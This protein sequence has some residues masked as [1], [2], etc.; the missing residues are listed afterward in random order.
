MVPVGTTAQRPAATSQG[1]I[2]Y[3]TSLNTLESAN[4]TAWANVGSGSASSTYG[5]NT[6]DTSYFAI[7][8]G[9]TAQRPAN[10][11]LGALRWTSSNTGVEFYVGNN[12]WQMVASTTY[13][14][15]YIIVAGGGGGGGTEQQQGGGGGGAGGV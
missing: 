6:A 4:G 5:A 15:S 3:N 2:R 11:P 8:V 7:P 14:V 9:T 12:N 1:Y 13:A 10:A